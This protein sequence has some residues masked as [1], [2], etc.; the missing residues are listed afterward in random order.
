MDITQL[1][2]C[3]REDAKDDQ[4][5]IGELWRTTAEQRFFLVLRVFRPRQP[6]KSLGETC[7]EIFWLDT[8]QTSV[9]SVNHMLAWDYYRVAAEE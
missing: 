5:A 7:A 2:R 9:R 1:H 6:N 4:I 3:A 8:H